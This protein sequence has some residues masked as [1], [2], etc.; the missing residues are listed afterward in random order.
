[1]ILPFFNCSTPTEFIICEQ[2]KISKQGNHFEVLEKDKLLT[3]YQI[4]VIK[5]WALQP[6]RFSICTLHVLYVVLY[7]KK[8][9]WVN[10]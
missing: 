1:M 7:S 4:G 5:E 3:G 2:E 8:L 9:E 6:W 10:L